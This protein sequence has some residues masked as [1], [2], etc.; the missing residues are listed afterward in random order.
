M[1]CLN[2]NK[3]TTNPKYCS[4]S[5]SAKINGKLFPKRKL[6][7]L[8]SRCKNIRD[9]YTSSLCK[10]CRAQGIHIGNPKGNSNISIERLKSISVNETTKKCPSCKEILPLM[11]FY[12][13]RGFRTHSYCR[14]CVL[15]QTSDRQKNFK[16]MC[17]EYKGGKCIFCGYN[18]CVQ[19]MDF[20]H[21]D[22]S[23]KDFA[24]SQ[25]KSLAFTDVVRAELDKC[26]LL[27]ATCHREVH[28]GVI[29]L[30]P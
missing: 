17:V 23:Q 7:N 29:T 1:N 6:K 3:E 2:C 21:L 26:A 20:H 18:R 19:A 5:C 4:K 22:P 14:T 27:C 30:M 25:R 13:R 10:S 9:T 12:I 24:V 28:A 8:C 11:Q 16:L 15:K